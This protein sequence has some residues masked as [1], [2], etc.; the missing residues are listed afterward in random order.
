[1]YNQPPRGLRFA[2]PATNKPRRKKNYKY[3]Y[4]PNYYIQ[5]SALDETSTLFR[6]TNQPSNQYTNRKDRS[7]E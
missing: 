5:T 3:Y 2:L 7:A 1:M 4:Y 6:C